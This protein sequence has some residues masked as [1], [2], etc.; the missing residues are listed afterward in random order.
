M[1]SH[2]VTKS[3]YRFLVE[4][5]TKILSRCKYCDWSVTASVS[6]GLQDQETEHLK[7]CPKRKANAAGR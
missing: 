3:F 7:V 5:A 6:D 2:P 1:S 4:N